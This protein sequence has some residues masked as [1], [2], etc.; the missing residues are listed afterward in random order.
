MLV[1]AE[2]CTGGLI[3]KMITDLAGSSSILERGYITYSNQSKTELLDVPASILK[4]HGAV[5]QETARH[6]AAGA[7]KNSKA[8]IALSVT[9][10][11]GPGG[12]TD[13]KPVGLVYIGY[14]QEGQQSIAH[15]FHF[16]GERSDIREQTSRAALSLVL[17]KLGVI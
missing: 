3:A 4:E 13:E 5:S 2:S 17:E 6:M 7:L 10:I 11:A 12:G 9:G 16:I 15:E 8:Q 14:A 1:T